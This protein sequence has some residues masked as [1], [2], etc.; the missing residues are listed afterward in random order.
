MTTAKRRAFT[1]VELLVVIAII[2]LLMSILLPALARVKKQAKNVLCQSNL[3]QWCIIFTMYVGDNDGYFHK[4]M[5]GRSY[6][7]VAALRPYYS[8]YNK[9]TTGGE[10]KSE[11]DIRVCPSATK[12]WWDDGHNWTGSFGSA[13]S[14]WGIFSGSGDDQGAGWAFSGDCGSY[15]LNGWVCNDDQEFADWHPGWEPANVWRSPNVKGAGNIPLFMDALWVD[16]WPKPSDSPP[17]IEG[18][19]GTY[20]DEAMKQFCVNRH[21]GGNVNSLFVDCSVRQVGLKELWTLKWHRYFKTDATWT[22]AGGGKPPWPEWMRDFKQ[23]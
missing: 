5:G 15:G 10:S 11:K 23:Y 2:A 17:A 22:T 20:I 1:L 12:F 6:G 16:G 13:N 9:T 7:W 21:G 18:E 19:I 3:R 4:E 14:A 8:G